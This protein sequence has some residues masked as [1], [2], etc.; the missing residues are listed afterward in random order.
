MTHKWAHISLSATLEFFTHSS[1]AGE[2]EKIPFF[3]NGW[4]DTDRRKS[5][6]REKSI[7][8]FDFHSFIP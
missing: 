5:A 2:R 4:D 1:P 3:K 6:Y 8:Q 7:L